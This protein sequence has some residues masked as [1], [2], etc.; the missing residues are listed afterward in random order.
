MTPSSISMLESWSW[1]FSASG[2]W[3]TCGSRASCSFFAYSGCL[4]SSNRA[5]AS[6]VLVVSLAE[7][8]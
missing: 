7:R 6:V 8:V 1:E 2:D 5:Q 3:E 4:V